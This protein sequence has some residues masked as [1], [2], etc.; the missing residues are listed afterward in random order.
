[1]F[2]VSPAVLARIHP[3]RE[4]FHVSQGRSVFQFGGDGLISAGSN[5][6]LF[7]S[8]TRM[9]S[10]YRY[11]VDAKPPRPNVMANVNQHSWL[12]Y[13]IWLPPGIQSGPHDPGS[14]Q[15]E[16]ISQQTLELKVARYVD[17]VVHEDLDFTNYSQ[18]PT[19]FR[20]QIELDADFADQE[21]LLNAERQQRG[22]LRREWLSHLNGC[23]EFRFAYAV[24][25]GYSHQENQG[26]ARVDRALW[27]RLTA[28]DSPPVLEE[29]RITFY[30][31]LLPH[32]RWHACVDFVPWIEN[33]RQP[34]AS[35]CDS[36]HDKGSPYD[37]LRRSFLQSS[38][39]FRV[40][41][42]GTLMPV[43]V[44][45]LERSKQDL[46]AL[47]LY[48][49]DRR[50]DAWTMAAGLP[51]YIAL[52]G[53]DT[54]TAAWQAA[55]LGPEMMHGSLSQLALWQGTEV[56]DW[57]DEQPG[58]MLHEA[59][60][61][62][63]AVL[64][65]HPRTRYYGS[66]TTSAFYPVVVAELWHWTGKLDLIYP[67]LYPAQKSIQWL[68][69]YTRLRD[70]GF[71]YYRSRSEQGVKNQG[72]KDSGDA[73]V[74]E[75]GSQVEPPIAT[76]EEQGFVYAS[77]LQ[78]AEVLWS[79]GKKEEARQLFR[80][81]QELKHRF[82]EVFWMEDEEFVALGLDGQG[83]QIR[84]IT[85]NPGHC[86]ATGILEDARVETAVNRLFAAD[87]FSGW[88]IRTLSSEHPA[89]N[90]YSYHRGSIWP[91]EHGSFAIGFMRYG[92][93][94][95]LHQMA[96]ALIEAAAMFDY[97]RLPELFSGHP[98]D[99]NHPFPALYPKAN[100][101]QAWSASATI[102]LVQA[103]LG[104]YPYA[105]LNLLFV[106]PHLPDWL[107]ELTLEQLRVGDAVI[108]LQFFRNREGKSDYRV[109]DQ[110]GDLHVIWQPSPW[111]L[112]ANVG[113]RVRDLLLSL[114]PGR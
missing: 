30:I 12:G 34:R 54:L 64:H 59:H 83:R 53:R 19:R 9:I 6:G 41:F 90:P 8:K 61:N 71:Y 25:H 113:E 85:S 31:H 111:S 37:R 106:D 110:Q 44:V 96:R 66:I 65:C 51:L 93:W 86:I 63:L 1:M 20:F 4:K 24:E 97:Y 47:R 14:G 75:D 50:D 55:M 88:G 5:D 76:C 33:R 100:W 39:R 27:V 17:E 107:P 92:L 45:L 48:D 32:Q 40:P 58:K 42:D 23:A 67:L 28:A 105:P 26:V 38:T 99:K 2:D 104:L 36:S 3:H 95:Q 81:A 70:D 16:E 21:E 109:I 46:A 84:S 80:E 10:L 49:L 82:N 91:V 56:N 22:E 43:L 79:A 77:K 15:I 74:Y 69:R 60:D 57:R 29:G 114:S 78:F 35:A 108:S 18:S 101:P 68:D 112:V 94:G 103:L 89:Y 52:F 87:M 62:P 102:C 11:F 7:V 98:R 13:F 73:I 72:W